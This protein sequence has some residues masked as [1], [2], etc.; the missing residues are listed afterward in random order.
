MLTRV[1]HVT[2]VRARRLAAAR[3]CAGHAVHTGRSPD[4]GGP[5]RDDLLAH[6]HAADTP[7]VPL[8]ASLLRPDPAIISF[9]L[10]LAAI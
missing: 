1:T 8:A 3:V 6:R 7:G 2:L 9:S 5:G 4:G 10:T